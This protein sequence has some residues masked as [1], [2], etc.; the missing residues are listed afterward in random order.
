MYLYMYVGVGVTCFPLSQGR[1]VQKW[2]SSIDSFR[3]KK[4]RLEVDKRFRF[5]K[6][7]EVVNERGIFLKLS[8]GAIFTVCSHTFI[9]F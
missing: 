7:P 9:L 2:S 6:D 4:F 5:V 1:E 8:Y 3:P